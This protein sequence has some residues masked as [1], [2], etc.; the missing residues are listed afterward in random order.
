[1]E[2]V[3]PVYANYHVL[4]KLRCIANSYN[5]GPEYNDECT[6]Q[7]RRRLCYDTPKPS[8]NKPSPPPYMV[9]KFVPFHNFT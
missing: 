4:E 3:G 7:Y 1:M 8:M 5:P 9:T 2:L 6:L